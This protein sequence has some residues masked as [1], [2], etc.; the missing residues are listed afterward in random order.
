MEMQTL[1]V[2]FCCHLWCYVNYWRCS[3]LS[4]RNAKCPSVTHFLKHLITLTNMVL[5]VRYCVILRNL[6]FLQHKR[7]RNQIYF[8]LT[9]HRGENG[10]KSTKNEPDLWLAYL[11]SLYDQKCLFI[12]FHTYL[13]LRDMFRN[14]N[15]YIFKHLRNLKF[16]TSFLSIRNAPFLVSGDCL[17]WRSTTALD[18]L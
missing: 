14:N 7:P 3:L 4:V 11:V 12:V 16:L 13:I 9:S 5:V 2:K 18:F 6:L 15:T 1:L 8:F 10:C 17:K